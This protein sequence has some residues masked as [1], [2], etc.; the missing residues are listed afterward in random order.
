MRTRICLHLL[1]LFPF[2]FSVCSL[3][4]QDV[5]ITLDQGKIQGMREPVPGGY[6]VEIFLGIPYARAPVGELRFADP[7]P[8]LE[9]TGIR[10]AKSYRAVC[11][12]AP[13]LRNFQ[14]LTENDSKKGVDKL[15][16]GNGKDILSIEIAQ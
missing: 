7:Q 15:E 12:Q 1:S 6:E 9:W 4:E 13:F 16:N 11:P 14:P 10:D 3:A 2:L 5:V 8:P